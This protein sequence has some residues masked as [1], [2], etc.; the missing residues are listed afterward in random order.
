MG[1]KHEVEP[2]EELIQPAILADESPMP[3]PELLKEN[4][5]ENDDSVIEA[6]G[7]TISKRNANTLRDLVEN[8]VS[9]LRDEGKL[10]PDDLTFIKSL[11][12]DT[13]PTEPDTEPKPEPAKEPK[14]TEELELEDSIEAASSKD[15]GYT[16]RVDRLAWQSKLTISLKAF[17]RQ[18]NEELN[19]LRDSDGRETAKELISSLN[20][21]LETLLSTH[22][23]A[24]GEYANPYLSLNERSM[25]EDIYCA[26][27]TDEEIDITISA[28]QCNFSPILIAKTDNS[29][30]HP[31][32]GV[33]FR[34]DEPSEYAPSA[35]SDLPLY[36]SRTVAEEAINSV[37]GKPL[38][39]HGT[40]NCHANENIVGVMTAAKISDN[41]FVVD[42]H[43]WP[44]NQKKS[45]ENIIANKSG[46]G[47]SMNAKALGHKT[48]INGVPVFNITKLS[49][50]GANI[51][52]SNSATYNK[53]R[54]LT[55]NNDQVQVKE[56]EQEQIE[57]DSEQMRDIFAGL[58]STLDKVSDKI[59]EN[60]G[61]VSV[62]SSQITSLQNEV[63]EI[64][65]ERKQHLAAIE[66]KRQKETKEQEEQRLQAIVA[67]AIKKTLDTGRPANGRVSYGLIQ[68]SQA[69]VASAPTKRDIIQG[70][71][72]E[73]ET[74][75][76]AKRKKAADDP[77][78]TRNHLP[79]RFLI[80]NQIT[81]LK[82]QL[83]HCQ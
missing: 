65:A 66:A 15:E 2:I 62:L 47:M 56:P 1:D 60:N 25:V 79:E 74:T 49:I 51:L 73:L 61:V 8:L 36:V 45:I 57:M 58:Q 41:D 48:E 34:V 30:Y 63:S 17:Y 78:G 70:E 7:K 31:V 38:D 46:L 22:P 18:F 69:P 11:E 68:S 21:I 39:A 81:T 20:Q 83:A 44:Y 19:D 82:A 43:L 12:A 76:A 32:S 14:P 77:F 35:G 64:Q 75:L 71:I 54:I 55:A 24:T 52:Y 4:P 16:D 6:V 13:K 10:S 67:E 72:D 42:G 3:V 59:E 28:R 26:R 9:F 40:L 23:G 27:E 37:P 29:N 5:N 33:L 50:L 53:T 80:Q